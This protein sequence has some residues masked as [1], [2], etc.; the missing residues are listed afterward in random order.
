ME[1]DLFFGND[2]LEAG[3]FGRRIF[4]GLD[5]C[6]KNGHNNHADFIGVEEFT[7]QHLPQSIQYDVVTD[8]LKAESQMTV[9]TV[10]FFYCSSSISAIYFYYLKYKYILL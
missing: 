10:L 6:P 2:V 3:P 4:L 5:K 1:F 7:T 8:Y 9:C